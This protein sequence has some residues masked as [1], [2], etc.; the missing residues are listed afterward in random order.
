MSLQEFPDLFLVPELQIGCTEIPKRRIDRL[1]R[2]GRTSSGVG[3]SGRWWSRTRKRRWRRWPL[4]LGTNRTWLGCHRCR[5]PTSR[6]NFLPICHTEQMSASLTG[7]QCQLVKTSFFGKLV[8]CKIKW[9]PE[10]WKGVWNCE[11]S[12]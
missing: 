7:A 2:E 10:M 5:R 8:D 11:I 1:D 9:T 6:R 3:R 12:L 4:F